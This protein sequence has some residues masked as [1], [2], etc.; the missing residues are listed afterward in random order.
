MYKRQLKFL[1][2]EQVFKNSLTTLPMGG[3]KGEMCIRD[4]GDT[5]LYSLDMSANTENLRMAYGTG[6]EQEGLKGG[7][8]VWLGD[9]LIG[10]ALSEMCIRDR[11]PTTPAATW[12]KPPPL[13]IP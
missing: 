8:Y 6:N 7:Y 13:A 3:G 2:F 11:A 12:S 10:E 5:I 4:R 9:M 1:G